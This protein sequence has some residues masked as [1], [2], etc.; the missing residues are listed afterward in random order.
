M[1]LDANTLPEGGVIETDLCIIGGGAAGITLAQALVGKGREIVLL[2]S[3]GF[4]YDDATQ[5]LY[6]GDVLG[7]P[8][9]GLTASR[10]RYFGGSTNH[11]S[12][13]CRPLD[14]A[15]FETRRWVPDSGWPF[16]RATLEPYYERAAPILDLPHADFAPA[17]WRDSMSGLFT[18][19]ALTERLRPVVYQLSPP[20]RFGDKYRATL[21][22]ADDV[23]VHL[24]AN[25]VDIE[26]DDSARTV[27]AM[28]VRTL[29]GR[30]YRVRARTYVLATG[31]IEN[32]RIL[33]SS[34]K[35]AARG[36][37]NQH[38]LVGR[39]FMDH[40]GAF[41]ATVHLPSGTDLMRGPL[42]PRGVH[43]GFALS[44]TV[45][46]EEG[47]TSFNCN[48]VAA[49]QS[50]PEGYRA[51]RE[52]VRNLLRGEMPGNAAE[53]V[54]DVAT[55]LD[56]TVTGVW[57]RL[58]GSPS[59]LTI[60]VGCEPAP[61]PESRVV[62]ADEH[63]ALGMPQADVDWRLT[64]LDR[65]TIRRGLEHVAAALSSAGLGRTQINETYLR[66]D[67][68]MPQGSYHHIGTT[69]MA[70]DPRKGVVDRDGR[71]HGMSNLYVAGSSVFPTAGF[72]NP[73]MTIVA[74]TLRLADH[75][76][77]SA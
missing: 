51:L 57:D 28:R 13:F 68:D 20:T 46:A 38:D 18:L 69:R 58:F 36:L 55:D 74:L 41:A 27:E 50:Y 12:G 39:Y 8:M 73:T 54:G 32:A 52:L 15:D 33:L 14:A 44:E 77:T 63:D 7:N 2:E 34:N 9:A 60:D 65:R 24:H 72:A 67:F 16:D 25:V 43:V 76:D 26:T 59:E 19:E 1:I 48:V 62:L 45:R 22:E 21:E 42:G 64:E 66:D 47:L 4:D 61:N 40:P 29:E 49:G 56:G 23:R 10:L 70:D 17:R 6:E 3:G 11:W 35:F 71:V 53:L 75:L 31:A 37:G 30:G 5:D